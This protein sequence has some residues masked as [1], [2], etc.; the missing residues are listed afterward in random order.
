M[1]NFF[2]FKQ[3]TA[4]EI[5]ACLVGSEMCIRDSMGTLYSEPELAAKCRLA[6]NF[7]KAFT[8]TKPPA[9]SLRTVKDDVLK[10]YVVTFNYVAGFFV[11]WICG[12][13]LSSREEME[14]GFGDVKV[15]NEFLMLSLGEQK[16]PFT[17]GR[18]DA[19]LIQIIR[20][21]LDETHKQFN[22]SAKLHDC[23]LTARFLSHLY[24]ALAMVVAL[25]EGRSFMRTAALDSIKAAFDTFIR[26]YEQ[27]LG[28]P[29]L[30]GVYTLLLGKD[31]VWT[32]LAKAH[33]KAAVEF[34]KKKFGVVWISGGVPHVP[35][36]YTHLT[37]PT[38]R[39]V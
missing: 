14:E 39:E 1:Y 18:H 8:H 2:F 19:S 17:L 5:S 26:L 10:V 15:L 16:N 22:T 13:V 24:Q 34:G 3:K 35:V 20:K 7:F 21:A 31:E 28:N 4:Y 33:A 30:T 23:T 32:P 36:S 11:K 37:L 29:V 27:T 9:T 25:N 12:Q 38:N 6:L